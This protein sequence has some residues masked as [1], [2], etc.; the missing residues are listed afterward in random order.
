MANNFYS[1]FKQNMEAMGLPAPQNLF[2]TIGTALAT[3]TSILTQI[4]KFG[5]TVTVAEII[6]A[7]TALEVSGV[8]AACS[9]AFYVGAVIGSIAVATGRSI[10]GGMSIA[11]IMYTADLYNLNRTWLATAVAHGR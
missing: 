8:M 2:G 4:D 7:G 10:S 3:A 1:Y 5:P 9:A 11:D 6:G